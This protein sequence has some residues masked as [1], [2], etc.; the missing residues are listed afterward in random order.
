VYHVSVPTF[1]PGPWSC[2]V[3]AVSHQPLVL[4]VEDDQDIR[5]SLAE[6]VEA[7]GLG[8][9]AVRDGV[10]ALDLLRTG[11][12]PSAVFLDKWMPRLDGTG[13]LAAMKAD[14]ALATIPVVWMSAEPSHPASVAGHIEKPF[15]MDALLGLLGSL[16]AAA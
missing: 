2:T 10:E 5:E 16:C 13:V 6:L 12:R 4:V 11:P 14:P 15:D 1:A 7:Q 3:L 8:V 9:S